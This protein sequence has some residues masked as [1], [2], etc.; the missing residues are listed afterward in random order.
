MRGKIPCVT[1][2]WPAWWAVGIGATGSWPKCGEIDMME[3]YKSTLLAN[4]CYQNSGGSQVWDSSTKS[5]SSLGL[6]WDTNTINLY[7]DDALLNTFNVESATV[8]SYTLSGRR[9]GCS[10][11][12]RSAATTA[13]IP[14]ARPSRSGIMWIT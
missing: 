5:L 3:Y 14:R 8:G 11:I 2:S 9:S 12:L 1:G 7:C 10:S 6:D 13:A 4:V